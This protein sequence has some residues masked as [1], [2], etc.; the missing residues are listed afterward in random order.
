M[1]GRLVSEASHCVQLG[2]NRAAIRHFD[3]V[4]RVDPNLGVAYLT[5]CGDDKK[6]PAALRSRLT[7]IAAE[8]HANTMSGCTR[9]PLLTTIGARILYTCLHLYRVRNLKISQLA[10]EPVAAPA[11]LPA[12]TR[13]VAA[14]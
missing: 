13:P 4:L 5:R 1:N 11:L 9:M 7:G 12:S 2:D 8:G 14:P 6:L 10:V 3:E